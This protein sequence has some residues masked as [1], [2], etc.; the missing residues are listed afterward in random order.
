MLVDVACTLVAVVED[1]MEDEVRSAPGE[2]TL[3]RSR[4]LVHL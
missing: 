4:K 1:I 3:R 2:R